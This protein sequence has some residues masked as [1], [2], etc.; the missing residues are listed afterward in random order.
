MYKWL[1]T[2]FVIEWY[3]KGGSSFNAIKNKYMPRIKGEEP[4]YSY[5]IVY[6][7]KD[8]GYIQSY[9]VE[10]SSEYSQY[11]N[12][13]E[14]FAGIDLFIGEQDFIHKGLGKYILI[15]FL[16]EHIFNLNRI[17]GCVIDPEANNKSAIRAYEKAG[18]KYLKTQVPS[19]EET[20]YLMVRYKNEVEIDST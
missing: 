7:N 6:N 12:S 13:D 19:Q 8:I 16:R 9:M 20:A 15:S 1:N 11:L 4:V 14:S 3:D 2:D 10:N 5:V 18:F 17:V